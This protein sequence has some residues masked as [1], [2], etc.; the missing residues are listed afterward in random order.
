MPSDESFIVIRDL[1]R[2]YR[3]GD[4][5]VRALDGI[6]LDIERGDF[7]VL[8]GPSGSGKSTLLNLLGGLDRPDG[9]TLIVD[10]RDV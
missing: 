8:M 2:T 3:L 10:G 5:V 7:L 4:T 6:N 1:R 9:G